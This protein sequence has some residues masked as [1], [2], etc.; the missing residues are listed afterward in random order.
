MAAAPGHG[1]PLTTAN[2][3]IRSGDSVTFAGPI[4]PP[5][6]LKKYAE[7]IPNAPE[8]ILAMA[9]RQ[10]AHRERMERWKV[11]LAF[12][13][14]LFALIITLVS[15]YLGYSLIR[16]DHDIGGTVIG[17]LGLSGLVG[18]FVY[19]TRA[20]RAQSAARVSEDGG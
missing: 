4:P 20:R 18:V 17:G 1:I 16:A 9:E 15:L 14:V 19:G 13:G 5:E 7:T 8:R 11:I 3:I 2:I 6:L 12:L 10:S